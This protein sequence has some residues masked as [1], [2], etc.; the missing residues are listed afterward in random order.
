MKAS[1]AQFDDRIVEVTWDP[2][3]KS[4]KFMRFRDDKQDGNHISVVQNVIE[5]I[6]D[7]VEIDQVSLRIVDCRPS[8]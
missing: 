3:R 6:T 4:W 5:S 2:A 7:G 8:N 1:G